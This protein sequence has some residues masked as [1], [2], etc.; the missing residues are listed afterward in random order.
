MGILGGLEQITQD[1]IIIIWFIDYKKVE[2]FVQAY[3]KNKWIWL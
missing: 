1:I 2:T 3:N